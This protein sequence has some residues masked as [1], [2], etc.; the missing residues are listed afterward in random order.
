MTASQSPSPPDPA[1]TVVV[2]GPDG[3]ARPARPSSIP[4]A[5][6][7]ASGTGA[8]AAPAAA[9]MSAAAQRS[10]PLT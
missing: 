4:A 6:V 2:S 8:A 9:A 3:M 10:P 1:A 7:S 5:S